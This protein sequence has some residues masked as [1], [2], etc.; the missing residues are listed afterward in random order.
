MKINPKL[1]I[2]VE[3]FQG[4]TLELFQLQNLIH[5]KYL[6]ASSIHFKRIII[7]IE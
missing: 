6:K 2:H 3:K 7:V 5:R 1:Q 4:F